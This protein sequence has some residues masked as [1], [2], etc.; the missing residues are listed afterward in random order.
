MFPLQNQPAPRAPGRRG[1]RPGQQTRP[2]R[3]DWL[4][5][6]STHRVPTKLRNSKCLLQ[7]YKDFLIAFSLPS[8]RFAFLHFTLPF[9]PQLRTFPALGR[10]QPTPGEP[11]G[12]RQQ[13]H[14]PCRES[15]SPSAPRTQGLSR[16]FH[17]RDAGGRSR[18]SLGSGLR[19]T[20]PRVLSGPGK[21]RVPRPTSPEAPTPLSFPSPF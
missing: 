1:L 13:P 20:L 8:T 17:S 2:C 15:D 14:V 4:C 3:N 10:P 16:T 5:R 11:Q 12:V 6:G 19:A 9:L 18:A 21:P 7:F